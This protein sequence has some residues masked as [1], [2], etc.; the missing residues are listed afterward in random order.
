MIELTTQCP[1]CQHQF[2]VTLEQL[3]Q[4]KG[5]LRCP[6][7]AQIFDAYE[8]A[9][10]KAQTAPS[11]SSITEPVIPAP[12]PSPTPGSSKPPHFLFLLLR[13]TVKVSLNH[14]L[15]ASLSLHRLQKGHR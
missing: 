13:V 8:C 10:A 15:L 2:D 9:V 5:L 14:I 11:V 3:Q 4:R 6:R 7:C 12:T 1:Q